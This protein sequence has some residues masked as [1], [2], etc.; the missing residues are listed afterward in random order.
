MKTGH[1]HTLYLQNR[2]FPGNLEPKIFKNQYKNF[3][4]ENLWTYR[5]KAGHT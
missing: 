1:Y 3:G 5:G 4:T 2:N